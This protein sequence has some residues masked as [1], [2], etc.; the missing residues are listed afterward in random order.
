ML[1][2]PAN[3]NVYDLLPPN[4]TNPEAWGCVIAWDSYRTFAGQVLDEFITDMQILNGVP[5]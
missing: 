5:M 3:G 4:I 2:P 1:P